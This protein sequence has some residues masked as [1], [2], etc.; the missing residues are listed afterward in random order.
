[1]DNTGVTLQNLKEK[2]FVFAKKAFAMAVDDKIPRTQNTLLD[3]NLMIKLGIKPTRVMSKRFAYAGISTRIVAEARFT[4][5]TVL[6]GVPTGNTFLKV[7]VVRDLSLFYGVDAI[8]GGKLYTK[9]SS[10]QKDDSF[11][12]SDAV[13][14][15]AKAKPD[16]QMTPTKVTPKHKTLPKKL[17]SPQ[18]NSKTKPEVPQI[19]FRNLYPEMYSPGSPRPLWE[20]SPRYSSPSSSCSS[21]QWAIGAVTPLCSPTCHTASR[22]ARTLSE[23]HDELRDYSNEND[24]TYTNISR[25]VENE[26]GYEGREG[27]VVQRVLPSPRPGILPPDFLPCGQNCALTSCGCLRRYSGW[28]FMS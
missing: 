6:N 3:E 27:T 20:R 26:F 15:P 19:F 5:Q 23:N 1:M 16:E 24:D 25:I 21:P 14:T 11:T 8:A 9:L 22:R 4:T 17:A 18:N 13:V 2:T 10:T 7:F 28:D 12:N